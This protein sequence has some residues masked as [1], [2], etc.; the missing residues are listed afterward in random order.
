MLK[1]VEIVVLGAFSPHKAPQRPPRP[2][3][4]TGNLRGTYG[5]PTGNLR[6]TYGD[7]RGTPW[8]H[9][10]RCFGPFAVLTW[11]IIS[12]SHKMKQ[13]QK[14]WCFDRPTD[15]IWVF[16]YLP[17]LRGASPA[18]ASDINLSS[19]NSCLTDIKLNVTQALCL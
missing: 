12:S 3:I 18:H 6:G 4:P 10:N 19:N 7:L 17:S 2:P 9:P 11:P 15:A 1:I 5:E 16:L 14:N 13:N 8:G